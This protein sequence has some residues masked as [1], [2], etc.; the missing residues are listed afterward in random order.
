MEVEKIHVK[1]LP[2]FVFEHLPFIIN[3]LYFRLK[4][5]ESAIRVAW[6]NLPVVMLIK[7]RDLL[8]LLKVRMAVMEVMEETLV[9]PAILVQSP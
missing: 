7:S 4:T 8:V 6:Q 2:R 5:T 3:D 9:N 1:H